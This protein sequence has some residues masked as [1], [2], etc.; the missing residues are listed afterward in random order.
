MRT[1]YGR[2]SADDVAIIWLLRFLLCRFTAQAVELRHIE[3]RDRHRR[4]V[5]VLA[6]RCAQCR[7]RADRPAAPTLAHWY[8]VELAARCPAGEIRASTLWFD[9][10]RRARI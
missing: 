8:S 10:A 1:A 7:R 4:A 3:V 6:G 9:P 2:L 5:A